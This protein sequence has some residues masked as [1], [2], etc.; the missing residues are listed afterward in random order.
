MEFEYL[1]RYKYPTGVLL[2]LTDNC[3]L[4]CIYCFV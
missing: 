1:G 3:N 2:N 4:A